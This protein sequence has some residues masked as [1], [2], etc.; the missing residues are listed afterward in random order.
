MFSFADLVTAESSIQRLV[1]MLADAERSEVQAINKKGYLS[2]YIVIWLSIQ[3]CIAQFLDLCFY[4]CSQWKADLNGP[5][6][7][8]CQDNCA[9]SPMGRILSGYS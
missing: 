4:T 2:K 3:Y 1:H 9:T 7:H 8:L 6:T 5:T